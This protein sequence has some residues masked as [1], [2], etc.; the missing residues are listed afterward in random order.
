MSE[1]ATFPEI[2]PSEPLAVK[3]TTLCYLRNMGK[4]WQS[5]MVFHTYYL[6]LKRDIEVVPR[7]ML[8]TLHRLRPFVKFHV[9]RHFI[10]ITG[11]AETN[12][13]KYYRVITISLRRT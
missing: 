1:G 10:Y 11:H 7:M 12:T 6:Q 5:N 3:F 2:E 9:D 8:N 13:K 4:Q